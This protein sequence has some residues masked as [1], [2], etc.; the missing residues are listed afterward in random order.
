MVTKK[1]TID[2]IRNW[3]HKNEYR[4]LTT[5]NKYVIDSSALLK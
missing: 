4:L 2:M 1:E 3:I 5:I